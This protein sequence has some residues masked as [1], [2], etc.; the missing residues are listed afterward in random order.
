MENPA[1]PS[2]LAGRDYSGPASEAVQQ[3]WLDAAF[4]ALRRALRKEGVEIDVLDPDDVK[5][6]VVSSALRVLNNP[7]GV[8]SAS[9]GLD[10]YT[11]AATFADS[12]Q[13]VYFTTAELSGLIPVSSLPGSWAGSVKY[14]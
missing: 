5:D 10:D 14:S 2:D 13:D 7:G 6:V 12:T 4:R 3:N 1:Q 11:E 9:G 8:K